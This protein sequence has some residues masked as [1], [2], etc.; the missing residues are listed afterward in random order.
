M[1]VF[2]LSDVSIKSSYYRHNFASYLYLQS[3]ESFAKSNYITQYFSSKCSTPSQLLLCS[4]SS[5]ENGHLEK[6][7]QSRLTPLKYMFI[8]IL[9]KSSYLPTQAKHYYKGIPSILANLGF[10][11]STKIG[12]LMTHE[13]GPWIH[14]KTSLINSLPP[15]AWNQDASWL[16]RTSLSG[17][18]I[19][20]WLKS[21][22]LVSPTASGTNNAGT[23]AYQ[24]IFGGG[25]S[26]A[27]HTA[28]TGKYF[29]FLGT[30]NV[31]W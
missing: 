4:S 21:T 31:C 3:Y 6:L 19:D 30:G 13:Y 16:C 26:L 27:L 14:P 8:T 20:V 11:W 9:Q 18:Q 25:I 5:M 7:I 17:P 29:H 28:Y 10:V 24:D 22:K 2:V 23:E 12:N 1:F 15:H